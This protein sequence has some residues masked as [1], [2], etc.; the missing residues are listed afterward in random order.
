MGHIG[1]FK[2]INCTFRD[3]KDELK[4]VKSR[5]WSQNEIAKYWQYIPLIEALCR[6]SSEKNRQK[7]FPHK[8]ALSWGHLRRE[9]W[10][11]CVVMTHTYSVIQFLHLEKQ[12]KWN[13]LISLLIYNVFDSSRL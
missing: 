8:V 3:D 2:I 11:P 13:L 5:Q 4:R 9:T 12:I 1:Y 10:N 7:Y 6:S